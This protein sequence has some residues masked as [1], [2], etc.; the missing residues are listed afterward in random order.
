MSVAVQNN[1]AT[2][3]IWQG[4]IAGAGVSMGVNIGHRF[5]GLDIRVI[6]ANGGMIVSITD[7]NNYGREPDLYLI[8]EDQ[9]LGSELGKLVTM[10]Y[11]KKE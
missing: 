9:D 7:P 1:S 11:L 3:A 10:Y 2:N 4:A 8:H 6:T 5:N